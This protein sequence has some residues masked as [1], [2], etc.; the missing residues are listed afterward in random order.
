LRKSDNNFLGDAKHHNSIV[1][2]PGVRMTLPLNPQ[3]G[4]VK[5]HLLS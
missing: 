1:Y 4:A 3:T 2:F 5:C